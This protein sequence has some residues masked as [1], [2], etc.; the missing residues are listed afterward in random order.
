MWAFQYRLN[1]IW[2]HFNVRVRLICLARYTI[3]CV[4]LSEIHELLWVN[5]S[6]NMEI[7]DEPYMSQNSAL[8][9]IGQSWLTERISKT[10]LSPNRFGISW[11]SC[12]CLTTVL[13]EEEQLSEPRAYEAFMSTSIICHHT[14]QKTERVRAL[15]FL[16]SWALVSSTNWQI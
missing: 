2:W 8:L 4:L 6:F 16:V 5:N 11:S 12:C 9:V 10:G 13:S 15:L 3:K 14:S 1:V 7:H